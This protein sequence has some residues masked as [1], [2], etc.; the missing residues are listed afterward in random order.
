[1]LKYILIM[2]PAMGVE[3]IRCYHHG[4]LNPARLPI[5][6]RRHNAI[7]LAYCKIIV[8]RSNQKN[9]GFC[10][11]AA[12]WTRTSTVS[13]TPLKRARLPFRHSR[14]LPIYIIPESLKLLSIILVRMSVR[15]RIANDCFL[16]FPTITPTVSVK[17]CRFFFTDKFFCRYK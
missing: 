10:I 8:N 17:I 2:V 9:H 13:H 11:G 7:I 6:S 14:P 15:W 4:I 1:M 3:P 12:D 16:P 5:P